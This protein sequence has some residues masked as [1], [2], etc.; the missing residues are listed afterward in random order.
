MDRKEKIELLTD[1]AI[2]YKNLNDAYE[3][4]DDALGCSICESAIYDS[5][6]KLFEEYT[7]AVAII[8]SENKIVDDINEWLSWYCYENEM[9]ESQIKAKAAL[10]NK[11]RKIKNLNDLLDIIEAE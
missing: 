5:S 7:K 11:E 9:G 3:K 4:I 6:F 10:W 8:L 2:A 1:W